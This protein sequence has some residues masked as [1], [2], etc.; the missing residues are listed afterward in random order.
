MDDTRTCLLALTCG[1]LMLESQNCFS[2]MSHYIVGNSVVSARVVLRP[3]FFF[4]VLL[5]FLCIATS[6]PRFALR[7][8]TALNTYARCATLLLCYIAST[9][10]TEIG[11]VVVSFNLGAVSEVSRNTLQFTNCMVVKYP[12]FIL[13]V[14]PTGEQ[15]GNRWRVHFFFVRYNLMKATDEAKKSIGNIR[16]YLIG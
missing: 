6:R 4:L 15:M 12:N 1:S 2:A 16:H 3:R 11:S 9:W 10:V 13:T 7:V 14:I 8:F 5:L